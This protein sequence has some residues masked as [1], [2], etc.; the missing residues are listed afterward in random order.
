MEDFRDL[1]SGVSFH[2]KQYNIILIF[3]L[4]TLFIFGC[5]KKTIIIF[6]WIDKFHFI[7]MYRY[8]LE[9]SIRVL[10]IFLK[11]WQV[12]AISYHFIYRKNIDRGNPLNHTRFCGIIPSLTLTEMYKGAIPWIY[13]DYAF[14]VMILNV[15]WKDYY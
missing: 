5:H 7:H 13:R 14:G 9:L 15:V 12:L 8:L 1:F 10:Y 2:I 6:Y 11:Y 3:L 4:N